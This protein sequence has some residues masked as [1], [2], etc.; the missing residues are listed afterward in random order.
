MVHILPV[1]DLI[2]HEES[3]QCQCGPS[4]EQLDNG[5]FMVIHFALDGRE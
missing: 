5:E 3:A 1:N 2:E 4:V